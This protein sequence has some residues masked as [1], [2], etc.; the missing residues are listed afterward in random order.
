MGLAVSKFG[1]CQCS[2][3]LI[4]SPLMIP[5]GDL[6][7]M[8]LPIASTQHHI[9]LENIITFGMCNS[10]Q[11][12]LVIAATAAALGVHTP[13]PCIPVTLEPWE[14][15]QSG[16][17]FSDDSPALDAGATLKCQWG[18]NISIMFPGEILLTL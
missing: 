4:P 5:E 17:L 2:Y 18:G 14:A 8:G 9:P 7:A 6:S 13:M 15:T 12:P 3:G 11:N 16:L 1:L 10:S